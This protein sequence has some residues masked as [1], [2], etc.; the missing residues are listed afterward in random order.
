MR[1]IVLL[2]STEGEM[3]SFCLCSQGNISLCSQ[4]SS[5]QPTDHGIFP[6]APCLSPKSL[7]VFRRKMMLRQ[8]THPPAH[9]A[10]GMELTR[11][12]CP[13]F[14]GKRGAGHP[15]ACSWLNTATI[16]S[17]FCRSWAWEKG[18]SKAAPATTS[19]QLLTSSWLIGWQADV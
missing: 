6:C 17:C 11:S 4:W 13:S 15:C 3:A 12:Y 2:L 14:W 18:V 10:A 8:P 7:M 19:P 16:I 5:W 1:I 9:A